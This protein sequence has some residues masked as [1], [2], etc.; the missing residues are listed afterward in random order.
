MGVEFMGLDIEDPMPLLGFSIWNLIVFI[1]VLVVGIFIVK[2]LARI[3][4]KSFR[5]M[6]VDEILANFTTRI[7]KLVLYIFVFGFAI[8]VLGIDLGYALLSI[9]VV[10]GFVLGFALGD[11]LGNIAAGFMISIT[12]PFHKGDYVDV[13]GESGSIRV[14]GITTTEMDTVDNKRVIIPN[15]LVWSTNVINYTR[16]KT[17][18]IDMEVA[19]GYDE[20]VDRVIKTTMDVLTAHPKVLKNPEPQVAVNEMGDSVVKIVARPWVK[21]ADYWDVYFDLKKSLKD[22]FA[23]EGFAAP[24]TKRSVHIIE[25]K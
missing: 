12:K 4:L 1:L 24:Y 14:V 2:L 6:K 22:S 11:T 15:R 7:L 5:K 16:N 20:N 10:M 3:M 21:T 13:S 19:A 8:G 25:R 9:A 18:R 23:T 17:R